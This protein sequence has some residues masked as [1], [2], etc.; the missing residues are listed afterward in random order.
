MDAYHDTEPED[1]QNERT[2]PGDI[3]GVDDAER[4]GDGGTD[5]DQIDSD[6]PCG[7]KAGRER[8][9]CRIITARTEM[10]AGRF[11]E[12]RRKTNPG[13]GDDRNPIVRV[14]V[15][16]TVDSMTL[17]PRTARSPPPTDTVN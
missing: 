10:R 9:H 8:M 13:N 5:A 12:P 16:A 2:D 11:C 17:F 7:Q 15:L 6:V 14:G 3:D 1:E 4:T